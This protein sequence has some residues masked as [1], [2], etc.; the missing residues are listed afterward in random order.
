MK[1]LV[2]QWSLF[3]TPRTIAHQAP[4]FMEFSR[5]EYW[6][7]LPFP[8]PGDLGTQGSNLSILQ[9]ESLPSEP[10]GKP[11]CV[12]KDDLNLHA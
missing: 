6:S 4:L 11:K 2:T 1:V 10:L 8:S 5:K 7:R 3:A 12:V 9:M